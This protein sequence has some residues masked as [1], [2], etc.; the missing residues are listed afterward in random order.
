MAARHALV[1][2]RIKALRAIEASPNPGCICGQGESDYCPVHNNS[3]ATARYG[4]PPEPWGIEP[5]DPDRCPDCGAGP[6]DLC[7]WN[8]PRYREDPE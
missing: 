8:C 4:P 5:G 2:Q 3:T 7:V 1:A 6:R